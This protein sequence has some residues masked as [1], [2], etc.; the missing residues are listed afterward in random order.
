[1]KCNKIRENWKDGRFGFRECEVVADNVH[2][3]GFAHV[4]PLMAHVETPA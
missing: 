4:M 1:M 2:S 3:G